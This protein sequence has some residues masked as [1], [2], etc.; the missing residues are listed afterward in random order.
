MS[1]EINNYIVILIF[2]CMFIAVCGCTQNPGVSSPA[3]IDAANV[4]ADRIL[5][6]INSGNY[7]DY[8][9]NFSDTMM[10]QV[11]ESQFNYTRSVVQDTFGNYVSRSG[12]VTS[13]IQGYNVFVYN[14][15]FTKGYV[16]FQLTMNITDPS[17]VEGVFF[18]K[19]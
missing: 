13:V 5:N 4:T 10:A 19:P 15:T 18:L 9:K 17:R 12:P 3:A 6:S 16:K 2:T 14:C 11:N 1:R 8:S 7:S